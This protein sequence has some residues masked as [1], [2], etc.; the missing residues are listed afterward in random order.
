MEKKPGRLIVSG[1]CGRMGS[2]LIE[3]ALQDH[4]HFQ[5]VGGIEH[6]GHPQE[7]QP[8]PGNP[9]L[10]VG[11]DLSALL[12]NADLLIEFST[13]EASISHAKAAAQMKVPMIIGTTGFSADQ[14]GQLQKLAQAIPIFWSPNMSIGIVIVRRAITSISKLLLNFGLAEQTKVS[15][16]ETHHTQKKDSPSGT[17]K[18]LAQELFKATGWLIKDEEIEARREGDVVGIHSVTFQSGSEKIRLEN[19]ALDRRVF[20][21]GALLVARG[22]RSLFKKPGW[23]GMDDFVSAVQKE[24]DR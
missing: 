7:G 2:L 3:E 13:P 5:L 12:K 19:E 14:L 21:Q 10:R 4:V 1:C 24:G 17:A 8:L 22:F 20:A 11:S 18:A 15:I 16:C 6:P 9:T 23:Y